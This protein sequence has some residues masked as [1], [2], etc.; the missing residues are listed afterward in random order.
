MKRFE[1]NFNYIFNSVIVQHPINSL[2]LNLIKMKIFIAIFFTTLFSVVRCDDD[3]EIP[4]YYCE[5][6]K[7]NYC[8]LDLTNHNITQS[9]FIPVATYPKFV[10][11]LY[12][13][14]TQLPIFSAEDICNTFPDLEKIDVGALAIEEVSKNAFSKCTHLRSISMYRNNITF[15][16]IKLLWNVVDLEVLQL[17]G[18][19]LTY[20][21]PKVFKNLKRLRELYLRN[22]PLINLDADQMVKYMPNLKEIYLQD[23]DIA[24][25]RMTD[26]IE[27]FEEIDAIIKTDSLINRIRDYEPLEV[28]DLICLTTEQHKN[29]IQ[30]YLT[31]GIITAEDLMTIEKLH[32]RH[33]THKCHE[34]NVIS[35]LDDQVKGMMISIKKVTMAIGYFQ[36][37]I[38]SI[39]AQQSILLKLTNMTFIDFEQKFDKSFSDFVD[40]KLKVLGR[41]LHENKINIQKLITSVICK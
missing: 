27:A 2:Q 37:K 30:E 35:S 20:I 40:Q 6:R 18:N 39:E 1:N 10:N 11:S 38:D 28:H 4:Q 29:V 33:D 22:N 32:E 8:K 25:E 26:I 3:Y 12:I 16:D 34:G 21:H 13:C 5:D 19:Q 14:G 24:C 31:S 41:M 17:T 23:T 9:R 7:G 36:Q 15:L